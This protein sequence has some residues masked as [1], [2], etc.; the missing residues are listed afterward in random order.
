M[1]AWL[2]KSPAVAAVLTLILPVS[3]WSQGQQPP[4]PVGVVEARKEMVTPARWVPGTVIS[5]E[6]SRIAAE[7]TGVLVSVLE[8]GTQARKGEPLARLNDREL[9]LQLR[10]DNAQVARL[11]AQLDY[12]KRQVQRVARLA[13][14]NTAA[15]A[16][17][18]E[19]TAQRDMLEQEL[20]GLIQ[21]LLV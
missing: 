16:N 18:D 15:V 6:D 10:N 20:K 1:N 17:L 2:K 19:S 7:V 12:L 3:T 11:T 4:S 9:Q 5:R 13:E 8:V 21:L 14:S